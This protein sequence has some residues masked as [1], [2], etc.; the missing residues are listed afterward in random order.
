V[1]CALAPSNG[2][3][4]VVAAG[5]GAF[6]YKIDNSG[7]LHAVAGSPFAAG[8]GPNGISIDPTDKRNISSQTALEFSGVWW[9]RRKTL[10]KD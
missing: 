1:F 8:L 10:V 4:V 6:V 3:F 7:A 5:A 9:F 2:K